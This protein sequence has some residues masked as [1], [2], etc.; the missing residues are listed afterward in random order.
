MWIDEFSLFNKLN[1]P[2]SV[3]CADNVVHLL[4]ADI[5][6]GT[7]VID[8]KPYIPEYDS[9]LPYSSSRRKGGA[10]HVSM[11][12][13]G[14][15]VNSS[16]SP[17]RDNLSSVVSAAVSNCNREELDCN[18]LMPPEGVSKPHQYGKAGTAAELETE[19]DDAVT[20]ACSK[21][22]K[23]EAAE[24]DAEAVTE[25]D[26]ARTACN[27]DTDGGLMPNDVMI[28]AAEQRRSRREKSDEEVGHGHRSLVTCNVNSE[29]GGLNSCL[30]TT[31]VQV[32][33]WIRNAPALELTVLFTERAV[34]ELNR[35][36]GQA[37]NSNYRLCSFETAQD[38]RTA[39]ES[40]LGADPRSVYRRK[41][42]ADR[43]YYMTLDCVHVTCW[44]DG[45]TVE[46]VKICPTN[47]AGRTQD[48]G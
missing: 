46:V 21:Y 38:F 48:S 12:F 15:G 40:I 7:P 32:A 9:V 14:L 23:A 17:P 2:L 1:P 11:T 29:T 5:L 39:L 33:E 13:D 4:G 37:E 43:L 45:N 10:P 28:K 22:L 6:D 3:L 24:L 20:T 27:D 31:P 42:C 34:K 19:G 30:T 18:Q 26:A 36:S 8:I 35:F 25:D 44:F 47:T 16:L 41:Q